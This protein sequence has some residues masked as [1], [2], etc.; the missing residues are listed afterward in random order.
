MEQYDSTG[1]PLVSIS[2]IPSNGGLEEFLSLVNI[3]TDTGL[4]VSGSAH[5]YHSPSQLRNSNS[6][7]RDIP[8]SPRY[9][10]AHGIQH[11]H[12][13]NRGS[14]FKDRPATTGLTK[15]IPA[16]TCNID[17]RIENG[18]TN[19]GQMLNDYMPSHFGNG[20]AGNDSGK[21]KVQLMLQKNLSTMDR[22][23]SAGVSRH[24]GDVSFG[25]KPKLTRI[26]SAPLQRIKSSRP[27]SSIYSDA[28]P[29]NFQL[30]GCE[31]ISAMTSPR[32]EKVKVA[33]R[34]RPL[35]KI[36][37]LRGDK[38]ILDV[39]NMESGQVTLLSKSTRGVA[40]P[41]GAVDGFDAGLSFQRKFS[42]N[43]CLG[44]QARQSEVIKLCGVKKMLD[45]VLEGQNA[46]IF[47]VSQENTSH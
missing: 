7:G 26:R 33:I 23:K 44:P 14:R 17:H 12:V 41:A 15:V 40:V 36:E 42:F 35:N 30:D 19:N 38:D 22:A 27:C 4:M 1:S 11:D 28:K 32:L 47:A 34:I 45:A 46:V 29:C 5:S 8:S 31:C 37:R 24:R 13:S 3:P 39:Q 43:C 18:F 2:S 21:D 10:S 9:K 20:E 16:S 25:N 6:L